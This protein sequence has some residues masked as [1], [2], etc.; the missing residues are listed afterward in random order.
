MRQRISLIPLLLCLLM[1][2][3]LLPAAAFA[4]DDTIDIVDELTDD[5]LISEAE[6]DPKRVAQ[7]IGETGY[8][9]LSCDSEPYVK[10]GLGALFG[11]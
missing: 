11:R 5:T 8:E 4:D 9:L 6:L 3:S 10:K 2:M 1:L 7:V